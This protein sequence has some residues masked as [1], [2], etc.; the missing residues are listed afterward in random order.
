MEASHL[1]NNQPKS[2]IL[3]LTKLQLQLWSSENKCWSYV[4]R[5][6]E[7][8]SKILLSWTVSL[9]HAC[10]FPLQPFLCFPLP[11][12]NYP[13]HNNP[14]SNNT[15]P[16]FDYFCLHSQKAK[17]YFLPSNSPLICVKIIVKLPLYFSLLY[18]FCLWVHLVPKNINV[19]NESVFQDENIL[20]TQIMK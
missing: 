11:H 4:S 17:E 18:L 9:H 12:S 10:I 8:F 15:S 20:H 19:L 3:C 2:L 14:N 7:D 6:D 1:L 5:T 13:G 16:F